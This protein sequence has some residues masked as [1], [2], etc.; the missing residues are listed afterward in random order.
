MKTLVVDGVHTFAGVPESA[1]AARAWITGCLAGSPAADD[2]ALM[3]SE[4][5]ANAVLYTTSGHVGGLVTVSIAISR[6]MARIHVIDQGASLEPG[7]AAPSTAAAAAAAPRLGAGLT[8][9]RELADEF[10]TDGPDKCFTLRVAGPFQPSP[11][12]GPGGGELKRE[13]GAGIR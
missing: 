11:L 1:R 2:A 6:G 10:V 13:R 4:L 3:V 5:F 7:Q 9:V 8:I 12:D